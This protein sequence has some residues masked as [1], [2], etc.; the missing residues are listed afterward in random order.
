MVHV[1]RFRIK[2]RKFS[3]IICCSIS[4]LGRCT[5]V[6]KRISFNLPSILLTRYADFIRSYQIQHL[7]AGVMNDSILCKDPIIGKMMKLV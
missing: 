2:Q 7:K 3:D 1:L 6:T 4:N 5:I